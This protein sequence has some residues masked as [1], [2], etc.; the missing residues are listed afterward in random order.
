MIT[1]IGWTWAVGLAAASAA[2]SFA[3]VPLVDHGSGWLVPADV[4][5]SVRAALLVVHG[6]WPA[7]YRP[8]DALEALPGFEILLAPFVAL[9]HALGWSLGAHPFR[10]ARPAAWLVVGPVSWACC[11]LP[12][13][14]ADAVLGRLSVSGWRRW[15]FVGAVAGASF[16][17]VALWGHPEDALALGFLLF[18]IG[19]GAIGRWRASAWLVG[20][21]VLCQPVSL[22]AVP[23]LVAVLAYEV[24]W[25]RWLARA[26]GPALVGVLSLVLGGPG[27]W[28]AMFEQGNFT[29]IDHPTPWVALSTVIRPGLVTDGPGRV[30]A[31]LVATGVGFLCS[32]RDRRFS[33]LEVV[34]LIGICLALRCVFE[35]VMDPYYVVPA[36]V[37]LLLANAWDPE[38]EIPIVVGGALTVSVF[39]R[40]GEW[41]YYVPLVVLLAWLAL[42]PLR[43]KKGPLLRG[44]P[45]QGA[46]TPGQGGLSGG[47]PRLLVATDVGGVEVS[48]PVVPPEVECD[49]DVTSAPATDGAGVVG[50]C[51]VSEDASVLRGCCGHVSGLPECSERCVDRECVVAEH[52]QGD[53]QYVEVVVAVDQLEQDWQCSKQS[54]LGDPSCHGVPI[55]VAGS[56]LVE[57]PEARADERPPRLR[58]RALSPGERLGVKAAGRPPCGVDSE[59]TGLRIGGPF[60]AA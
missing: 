30:A 28:R 40:E 25:W 5:F 22:L 37:F 35:S 43:M 27:A 31:V 47:G 59:A 41:S 56:S 54:G 24:D 42:W 14:G 36:L 15:L 58:K 23:V 60:R 53:D 57:D 34:W 46:A 7:L 16:Q 17:T 6:E 52:A 44:G 10:L 3:W 18:A 55:S 39:M 2:F 21:G 49:E 29:R 12:V 1:R 50:A 13:L 11:S 8:P 19:E 26:I 48:P 45:E 32:S 20:F 38:P 51:L 33:L 9:L 4:W